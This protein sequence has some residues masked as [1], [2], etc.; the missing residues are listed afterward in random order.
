[1]SESE[2]IQP[3]EQTPLYE[4]TIFLSPNI[5]YF[6]NGDDF[7]VYHNLYG[8]ILKMSEDLVDF[9]EFFHEGPRTAQEMT[10]QFGSVFDRDTL[11]EFL[12]IFRTLACLL[13]DNEYEPK[14]THDMYPTQARWIT[15]DQTDPKAVVIYAFDVQAQNQIFKIRLDAWES[16]LWGYLNGTKSVGEIAE[17]LAEEDGLLASD[18]ELRIAAAL[19]QWTHCSIQAIKL[20][21]EPCGNFKGRRFGVP[22]YLISTMPYEK[23]TAQVRT[24]VDE[25]GNILEAWQ[26]P[27][28]C[29]PKG[30][31][32][33]P[34]DDETLRLDRQCA[35]LSSLLAQPHAVLGG[36]SYGKAVYDVIARDFPIG[37]ET[38]E[39]LEVGGG[40]GDTARAFV[41]ECRQ[42]VPDTRLSYT[43]FC[44]DPVQADGLRTA[45]SDL[46]EIRIL[47]G[48]IEKIADLAQLPDGKKYDLIYS[49]EFLA[50]LPSVNVRKMSLD[51]GDEE[52]EE[53]DAEERPD[54]VPKSAH[55][56]ASRL[57]FIGEGD[58]V[59]LIIR[60]K[61]NLCDAPEDFILN[62]GSLRLLGNLNQLAGFNTQMF[63]I[64]FGEDVKY[65]VRTFEDGREAWSQHFGILKQAAQKLGFQARSSYWMEALDIDRN[66]SMFATTRSQFKAIRCLLADHGVRLERRPYSQAE[67]EALLA[68]AGLT[69]VD[70]INY[71]HA[72][73]RISGLVS[74]AYKMLHIFKELEF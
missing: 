25:E 49:D 43:I 20:S 8:Y 2:Q 41:L 3:Q 70:E 21:A 4:G 45:L 55:A 59:N 72:E 18:V 39:V 65:P 40:N 26:E 9:L 58:A 22:P 61:L 73:E 11:N 48:D 36:R 24:R 28:R 68:Q 12:S 66:L 5:D 51:G 74:H 33:L 7:F 30:L 56:D 16:R 31:E 50:D 19:A 37:G 57:T 71:E 1:M 15:V 10:D 54:G 17:C 47:D 32:T 60:Y 14:K 52:D 44:P 6:Q 53:E 34:I 63:I 35:R 13:P 67:F 42:H 69:H 64:E 62:S 29:L 38:C 27:E 23:V 46:S